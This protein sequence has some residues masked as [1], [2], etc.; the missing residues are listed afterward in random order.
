MHHASFSGWLC[1]SWLRERWSS[2]ACV[3]ARACVYGSQKIW[4]FHFKEMFNIIF[5]RRYAYVALGRSES[6]TLNKKRNLI[7][8]RCQRVSTSKQIWEF[9]LTQNLIVFCVKQPENTL[10]RAIYDHFL[11]EILDFV[12]NFYTDLFS[13]CGRKTN[14]EQML[15]RNH[16]GNRSKKFLRFQVIWGQD[17]KKWNLFDHLQWENGHYDWVFLKLATFC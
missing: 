17:S 16:T 5:S 13:I 2:R 11:S 10:L 4:E 3:R 8:S 15:N 12:Q 14:S 7:V 9:N 6:F 1:E